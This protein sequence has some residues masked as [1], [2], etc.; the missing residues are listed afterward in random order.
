VK[1]V[2][3]PGRTS[4][5]GPQGPLRAM[6]SAQY[7]DL[8]VK[9]LVFSAAELELA[10]AA[11][12]DPPSHAPVRITIEPNEGRSIATKALE[13]QVRAAECSF[14]TYPYSRIRR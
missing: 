5:H 14:R 4:P 9:G 1:V 3:P 8:A 6:A 13:L 12:A 11:V 2:K 7:D 10:K